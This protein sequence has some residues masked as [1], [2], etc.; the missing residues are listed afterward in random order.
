VKKK[1]LLAPGPTPLNP[2]ALLEMGK[3]IIHHRAPEFATILAQ[4]RED[5]KYLFQTKNDVLILCSS[6][7][8]GMEG[9]VCN[10]F[11]PGDKA[12][13]VRGGKFGER[14]GE[15]CQ[16]YG[17]ET[18]N[19][20]VEWGKAVDPQLIAR[21]LKNNPDIK[22][23]F[24]QASESSTGVKHD[25]QALGEIVRPYENT[26]LIVDAISALGVFPILTDKWGLDVVVT[27]SQK[28]LMLPPGLAMVALS[29][30]AWSFTETST[31]PKYYF[32]FRKE[33]K[34][35]AQ[36][37]TAY[38][39]AVSLI[40]GLK[41]VLEEIK[42]EGLEKVFDHHA[43]L[44]QATRTAMEALGLELYAKDSPSDAVTAV[45][46]PPG[47]DGAAIPRMMRDQFGITIAGGQDRAKG[48]I[49]RIAHLGYVDIFDLTTGIA[50][51][52]MVLKKLG[53]DIT[54]GKG[55]GAALAVYYNNRGGRDEDSG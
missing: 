20:D 1:Y 7:T 42:K 13:V 43:R 46:V 44:A 35:Q 9:T 25:V 37:Q 28:A 30:K 22:G 34:A 36:N 4:V 31:C 23:V 3:P 50:A 10:L 49:F 32:N 27:G 19:I 24:V 17:L 54:F 38:T 41:R 53:Y 12:L 11:S 5:L 16:V 33:K 47:I 21:E 45:K 14:W 39:P 6:G 48:K 8:G 15:L 2:E 18:I 40:I 52:E 26:L 29:E 51:L 55:V